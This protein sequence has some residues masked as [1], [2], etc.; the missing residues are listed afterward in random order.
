[1]GNAAIPARS[2]EKHLILKRIRAQWPPV[3]EDNGLAST[4]ILE[5]NPRSILCRDRAHRFFPMRS[6]KMPIVD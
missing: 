4:P 1:V 3:T 5:I 6:P 2:Q